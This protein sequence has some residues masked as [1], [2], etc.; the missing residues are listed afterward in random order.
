MGQPLQ[1]KEEVF[2]GLFIQQIAVK[3]QRVQGIHVETHAN[4]IE[5]SFKLSQY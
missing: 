5:Q 3:V 2:I 4:W 1:K